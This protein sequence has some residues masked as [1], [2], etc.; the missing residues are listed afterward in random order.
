MRYGRMRLCADPVLSSAATVQGQPSAFPSSFP[1]GTFLPITSSA[2]C[3]SSVI[4]CHDHL[5]RGPRSEISFLAYDLGYIDLE[6]KT[7]QTI[8]NPFGPRLLPMS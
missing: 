2:C 6:Q 3:S 1:F 7:L 8:D 4:P 5:S